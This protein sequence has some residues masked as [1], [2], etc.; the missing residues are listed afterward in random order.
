MLGGP[1]PGLP[2]EPRGVRVVDERQR[3]VLL[4]EGDDPVERGEVAVHGED[5]VG[6]DDAEPLVGVLEELLLEVRHVAVLVGVGHRLAEAHPVH[7]RGVDEPVR[8]EDVLLAEESLEDAGVR[9]EA[10][11][12]EE[13]LLGPEEGRHPALQLAM[14]VLRAADEADGGHAVAP[15]LEAGVGGRDD[16]GVRGEAEVVVRAEVEDLLRRGAGGE[17]D[18]DLGP[19]RV[20]DEA[21][22]LVEAG[23]TN[24]LELGAVD[25]AEGGDG[26]RDGGDGRVHRQALTAASRSTRRGDRL[27]GVER[28]RRGVGV[29]DLHV[30]LPLQEA[31]ERHHRERVDDAARDEAGRGD[32]LPVVVLFEVLAA[33]VVED[34]LAQVVH[35]SPPS[36][37][38]RRPPARRTPGRAGPASRSF[39]SASSGATGRT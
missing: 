5:A 28:L 30:V 9:V 10:G 19:L 13:G 21:F 29:G 16:A 1:A 34:G 25:V 14:D 27:D 11:G 37:S 7:D 17:L 26:G 38:R 15:V 3:A 24:G 23:G 2:D 35:F 6:D 12:E 31:L 18:L 20:V 32:E 4:G 33:D 22:L 36:G 39:R 8:D